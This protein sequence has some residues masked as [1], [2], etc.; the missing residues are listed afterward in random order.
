MIVKQK[1]LL[2]FLLIFALLLGFFPATRA[3]ASNLDRVIAPVTDEEGY[4][5]FAYQG[6][7][8]TSHVTLAG[9]FNGWDTESMPL[10]KGENN[11]F[12][13]TLEEKL[14]PATYEYKFI[15]D[16]VW[17]E[18]E[19]LTFT[20]E[21]GQELDK[22]ES[23]YDQKRLIIH[24]DNP[25]DE[26]DWN[27]WAWSKVPDNAGAQY[28]FE[29]DDSYGSFLEVT[30]PVT[31]TR[32][33]FIL[34]KGDGWDHKD[35]EE[36]RFVDL[37]EEENH[38]WLKQG[39]PKVY[40]EN[41]SPEDL[42]GKTKIVFHF[43][44]PTDKKWAIWMWA[45][46]LEGKEYDFTGEDSFG[47]VAEIVLDGEF[48]KLGFII[49]TPGG[50]NDDTEK[51]VGQDRF[52]E[53]EGNQA[54]VWL[55]DR[56]PQVYRKRP[57]KIEDENITMSSFLINTFRDLELNLSRRADVTYLLNN[58]TLFID[59]E[60]A[61]TLI[62]S[63]SPSSG[64][65]LK[66]N[67]L[68]I[69]LK[70]DVKLDSKII[71]RGSFQEDSEIQEIE[72]RIGKLI[73][74]EEF[75]Q[76]FK[77]DGK[78]GPIYSKDKT[79]FRVWAPTAKAVDLLI[80]NDDEIVETKEMTRGDKGVYTASLD[81]DQEGRVYMYDVH[82][83]D[84]TN[85][86]VDPY[87]K[88]VTVNGQRSVVLNPQPTEIANP[89]NKDI[90]NPIIYELHVRDL[91]SQDISGIKDKGTF[92]G[93]VESG[94]KTASGQITGF[95]YIKS[96][97]ITHVQLLPIYDYKTVDETNPA[98]GFNWGY[99]PLN[100]NS[101]EGSYSTDPYDPLKRIEELQNA[102]DKFHQAG[103]GVI[104]DVVYNHVFDPNGHAFEK[105]VPG[106]YFRQG[107]EGNFLGGT[108]VGNET[109]SERSMVQKYII[110]SITYWAKTFKLDGFRFDLMGTH[111]IET[112]NKIYSELKKINPNIIIHGEGWNMD[113]GIP[114]D[115]RATQINADK[116]PNI[117]F[118]NDDLR[119]GIR[120]S[121]FEHKDKG[122]ATGKAEKESFI[123]QSIKG[124]KGLKAYQD[125]GQLI[126]YVE[127]HD[128]LTLWDKIKATNPD[129]DDAQSLKRHKLATSMVMFA[130][131][132]P[133]IHAGQEFARTKGGD[134][135]SYKSD[136]S[137]NQIDWKRVEE[138][139]D[140]INYFRELVKIRKNF[141]VFNLKNYEEIDKIF[142]SIKESEG[143]I[144]YILEEDEEKSLIIAHNGNLEDKE[145]SLPNGSYTV[146]VKDQKADSQG[147]ETIEIKDEKITIPGLS[148]LTL[149]SKDLKIANK[150][151]LIELVKEVRAIEDIHI[152]TNESG[153][154]LRRDLGNAQQILDDIL[155]SQE[156]V[157]E[158]YDNLLNSYR[159]LELKVEDPEEPK[160]PEEKPEDP[161]EP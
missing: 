62:E 114:E 40:L 131:G 49:K 155:A 18:G 126:Q 135:N 79:E 19:N 91:S 96:L 109:A 117:G 7:E 12:T 129:E 148:S 161:E 8:T 63:I 64:D 157:D 46:G 159:N 92:N 3:D 27:I 44:N 70:E 67:S 51:N 128:N 139:S 101:V 130:Q 59:G 17:L 14:A 74:S 111:D 65:P 31:T 73:S 97:G 152:Y 116:L 50:W 142:T 99:D 95:D 121:V 127:A 78:L 123:L 156:D 42:T 37:T 80:F 26:D 28:N 119:D 89:I 75:D 145:L 71:F 132:S 61:N 47:H 110:D 77:Y 137:V 103:L 43:N 13:Y 58:Y 120:G 23:D 76:M 25:N 90:L 94:T 54:S 52:V 147:L 113:M 34:K 55:R 93:L 88:A 1:R 151:K 30:F 10:V 6:D 48:N 106:Y 2:S 144:A 83:A 21:S 154:P 24:F 36:D 86:S 118:F 72:A 100:Y 150:S 108:G 15:I 66:T 11:L 9:S 138:M 158:A 4:T 87:A 85:R 22:P 20:I 149:L 146:L 41:P 69:K 56:D 112:M 39:D 102:V 38:I 98:S 107:P 45:E 81:G 122:F 33:G 82:F 53:I 140:H 16:G 29:Y 5:T 153:E 57:M 133:F 60:N 160:D 105:I 136:D 141:S 104:M 84:K 143:V 35:I 125:A 32:A 68:L 124:G 134:D 115:Q